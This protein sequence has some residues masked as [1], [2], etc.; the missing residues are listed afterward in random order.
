MA[1]KS[2]LFDTKAPVKNACIQV[3]MGPNVF[4]ATPANEC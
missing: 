2:K 4:F 3:V 1:T